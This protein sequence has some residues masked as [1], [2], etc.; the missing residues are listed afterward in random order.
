MTISRWMCLALLVVGA[1]S[2][3]TTAESRQHS[4]PKAFEN[5]LNESS[6]CDLSRLD[7]SHR[8]TVQRV[9]Q[10]RNFMSCFYGF[11]ECDTK[12]LNAN[13]Q[14][15]VARANHDQ[16]L[17]NCMDGTGECDL[18]RLSN[19]EKKQVAEAARVRNLEMCL[20]GTTLA[21][22]CFS[23][24]LS[25]VWSQSATSTTTCWKTAWRG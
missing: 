21:A 14:R 7:A 25:C 8:Q 17:Q 3:R 4:D 13:Q 10:D 18:S 19:G 22:S 12:E 2:L 1:A 15:E 23:S 24:A 11:S 6:D 5:C 16:N 9:A 20:D